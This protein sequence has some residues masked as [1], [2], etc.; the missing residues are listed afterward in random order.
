VGL[1]ALLERALGGITT[2]VRRSSAAEAFRRADRLR[3]EGRYAE[4]A[5]LVAE[6]LGRSPRSAAGHLLAAY[7]HF[8]SR[9][10]GPAR[11]AFQRVLAL[12]PDHPRALLGLARLALEE[13][14]PDAAAPYLRRALEYHPDFPEATA[15]QEMIASWSSSSPGMAPAPAP[16]SPAMRLEPGSRDAIL[17]RDDGSVV[18]ADGEEARQAVLAHHVV[19]MAR[20]AASTLARAG[21]GPLRRGVVEGARDTTYL[22]TD[23]RL[24]L[25]VTMSEATSVGD[26]LGQLGRIW[27]EHVQGGQGRG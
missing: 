18:L 19:Q 9:E 23:G 3:H 11:D 22:L 14:H 2:T 16:A 8:S 12:D 25:S 27:D 24:V 20:I 5:A 4:A 17:A 7:L 13:G 10:M 21:L 1:A 6:G 26:G 15:L